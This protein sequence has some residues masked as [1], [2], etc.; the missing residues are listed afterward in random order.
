MP[1]VIQLIDVYWTKAS[2]GAPRA[3]LR[4][5]VPE[6]FAIQRRLPDDCISLQRV[7]YRERDDFAYPR[8]QWTDYLSVNDIL[9]LGLSIEAKR[10]T[11]E[12]CFLGNPLGASLPKEKQVGTLTWNSWLRIVSNARVATEW[13]WTYHKYAYNIFHG[14]GTKFDEFSRNFAP[15][16]IFRDEKELW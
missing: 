4:N 3:T 10:D 2:R 11:L 5:A 16:T 6:Q 7:A 1:I 12:V 8:E 13:T 15:V 14:D 9:R